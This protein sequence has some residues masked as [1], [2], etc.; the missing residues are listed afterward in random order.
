MGEGC[1]IRAGV[2]SVSTERMVRISLN[3]EMCVFLFQR[4][5]ALSVGIPLSL[6]AQQP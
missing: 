5:P 2:R 3:V 4:R 6:R 1:V